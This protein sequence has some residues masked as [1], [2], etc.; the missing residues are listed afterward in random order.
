[1]S[2]KS[3]FEFVSFASE[4]SYA[5]P[6]FGSNRRSEAR[7]PEMDTA[8]FARKHETYNVLKWI[9]AAV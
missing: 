6:N 8:R 4:A 3:I 9:E 7:L 2:S 5:C 1:M